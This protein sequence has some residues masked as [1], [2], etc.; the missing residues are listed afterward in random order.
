MDARIVIQ[1]LHGSRT[2]QVEHFPLGD[3]P[4]LTI[5]RDPASTIIFDPQRDDAVSRNHA[6]I[7]V[8]GNP[9]GFRIADLG[10]RNGTR[11]NGEV[12]VGEVEL[13]PGDTVE[14][15]ANGPRFMFDVQPRPALDLRRTRAMSMAVGTGSATRVLD[16]ADLEAAALAATQS[17]PPK[18]GVG[19]NTVMGMLAEQRG[20]TNRAWMY[21]LAGVLALVGAGG[22]G[23]YYHNKTKTE[24]AR[25]EA[26][27]A[28]EEQKT[29]AAAAVAAVRQDMGMNAQEVTRRFGN[30]TVVINAQWRL[31]DKSSGK[32]MYQMVRT[33][34]GERIP[35]YVEVKDVGVFRWLT[36]EDQGQSNLPIGASGRGTGFVIS[37]NGFILTN[38]HVA[39][40]WT[41]RYGEYERATKGAVFRMGYNTAPTVVDLSG[42]S[43]MTQQLRNWLPT[44]GGPVFRSDVPLPVDDKTHEF[45]GRADLLEVLFPGNPIAITAQ[46]VRVSTVADVA[47]IK[48]DTHQ[49]LAK[50][51]MAR[52]DDVKV[53][54]K[55]V[56]LGYP[57]F[58]TQTMA[59]IRST[60]AGQVGSKPQ[61]VPE[62]TVTEG[63]ISQKSET[64]Q[65]QGVL[66]TFGDMG[67]AYQLTVP[68]SA[69]N[70]GGPVFNAAGKVIALF[71][72]G[73]GRETVTY[74]VPIKHGRALLQVQ[75]PD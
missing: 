75:R 37:D 42:K 11:L 59:L 29:K 56:V 69:G 64:I 49:V 18:S 19:R 71:T 67:E 48:I 57:G 16:T 3:P 66:I 26:G 15:G 61:L 23:L 40:G 58:S 10:S 60:E 1:H 50:I 47:E 9:P 44:T 54:E 41:V 74:A 2:N 20:Q 8:Q 7:K 62:P 73:T 55:V 6:V 72:Y 45:V 24:Q 21:I 22:G 63:I 43:S 39:A 25:A 38:K 68:S 65:Q 27:V 46:I 33:V 5:G 30:A 35:C 32:P 12:I 70:S 51:E 4:E 31:Y 14:L 34:N 13:M 36:T 52:D 28:I 53:G 17:E